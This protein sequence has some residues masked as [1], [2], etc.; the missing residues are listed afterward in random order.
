MSHHPYVAER[1]AG[2]GEA[3]QNR[4]GTIRIISLVRRHSGVDF[5]VYKPTTVGRR[6]ARRMA[7][8][9]I[10][11]VSEYGDLVE[12]DPGEARALSQDVLIHVTGFFR[13][14]EVFEALERTVFPA[15][16]EKKREGPIRIWVPGCSSGEEV[17]TLAMSLVEH[18]SDA[19]REIE[20]QI[21]G[22]DLSDQAI[23]R[24]RTGLYPDSAVAGSR[25]EIACSDSSRAPGSE[26]RI[27]KS[28]RDRCVF[29]DPRPDARSPRSRSSTSSAAATCSSTSARSCTRA[30]SRCSTTA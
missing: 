17:Y 6:I 10:G 27:A 1:P 30:S 16:L 5:S 26:Q 2:E 28:I 21:F 9:R 3:P 20:F 25:C 13:D 22:S 4:D 14:P 18:Q 23:E 19:P 11:S 12:R 29:V 24:A 15:L 8:H 7:L